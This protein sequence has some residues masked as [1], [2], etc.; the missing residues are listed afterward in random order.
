MPPRGTGRDAAIQKGDR[1]GAQA[2][3]PPP[4]PGCQQAQLAGWPDRSAGNQSAQPTRWSTHSAEDQPDQPTEWPTRLI[5]REPARPTDKVVKPVGREP[6]RPTGTV[7][8]PVGRGRVTYP[9]GN[10]VLGGRAA[11]AERQAGM[12]DQAG[13]R[14][15]TPCPLPHKTKWAQTHLGNHRFLLY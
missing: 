11:D 9:G 7:V 1:D 3:P 10:H 4:T 13:T 5:G 14:N 6:A 2:R 8:N 12:A 15:P